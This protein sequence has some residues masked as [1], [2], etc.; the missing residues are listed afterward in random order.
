MKLVLKTNEER[1]LLK[2]IAQEKEKTPLAEDWLLKINVWRFY[3]EENEK[4]WIDLR[5][6]Y[7]DLLKDYFQ[8]FIYILRMISEDGRISY[9]PY[10][11]NLLE[12]I[13]QTERIIFDINNV[14]K[15]LESIP[16][17]SGNIDDTKSIHSDL[18]FWNF[19]FENYGHSNC[20][21]MEKIKINNFYLKMREKF[22]LDCCL[23]EEV[24]NVLFTIN[25]KD[26][27]EIIKEILIILKRVYP[28]IN[29]Q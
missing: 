12:D 7:V 26:I 29:S 6:E 19:I 14:I 11:K 9:L 17:I 22:G 16:S 4:D 24:P 1:L 5:K 18:K 25:S 13:K 23:I 15:N 28:I 8:A 10:L 3:A 20:F 2:R 27:I 21:V